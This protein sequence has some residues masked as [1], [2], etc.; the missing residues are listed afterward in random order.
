MI[1]S[2]IGS[3]ILITV[4]KPITAPGLLTIYDLTN[5]ATEYIKHQ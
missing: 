2:T 3:I 1:F 4:F 5:L